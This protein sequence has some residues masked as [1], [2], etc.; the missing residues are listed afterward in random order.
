ML[1]CS[2]QPSFQ[3]L[4]D[5]WHKH[6]DFSERFSEELEKV[7][8][9]LGYE[10]AL[11][12]TSQ[13][14]EDTEA[15]PNPKRAKTNHVTYQPLDSLPK[16]SLLTVK[17]TNLKGQANL[18]VY[19]G[20]QVALV[21]PT[22]SELVV[23]EGTA[24]MGFGRVTWRRLND[25]KSEN[26]GEVGPN[27]ILYTLKSSTDKI[28]M[29][30]STLTTVGEALETKRA[31]GHSAAVV[32]AYHTI[33]PS[34]DKAGGFDLRPKDNVVCVLGDHA[35]VEEGKDGEPQNKLSGTQ[36]NVA[37]C[38]DLEK[39]QTYGHC[40]VAWVLNWS[41][42]ALMPVRPQVSRADIYF[43]RGCHCQWSLCI[44][45]FCLPISAPGW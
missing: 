12:S 6:K 19:P 37:A 27:E 39:F 35:K 4:L 15:G 36:H 23:K 28:I 5:T 18:I 44:L 26:S 38:L 8:L 34:G 33:E 41:S 10:S 29:Q 22:D 16:D 2:L 9:E 7:Q 1:R 20:Q 43:S 45:P 25:G 14:L 11:L 17:V 13:T 21:N 30:P 40:R 24:I 3:D 32:V 42:L 31:K